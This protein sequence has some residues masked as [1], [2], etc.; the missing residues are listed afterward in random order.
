MFQFGCRKADILSLVNLARALY[1]DADVVCL[2]DPL[3]AVDAHVAEKLFTDAILALKSRGKS[4]V[5]VTHA[6]H[7]LP[8]VD[9]IYCLSEGRISEEGSY[10]SLIASRGV[11]SDLMNEFG[12]NQPK[13]QGDNYALEDGDES[14]RKP[15]KSGRGAAEGTGKKEGILIK[16]E[17]RKTGHISGAGTNLILLFKHHTVD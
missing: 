17:I 15:G 11:F 16:K 9:Y 5:L 2:D 13:A 10:A 3:S 4:V 1:S 12:S 6:L 7:F 8:Q 14:Q